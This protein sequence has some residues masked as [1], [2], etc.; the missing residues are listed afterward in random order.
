MW[1]GRKRIKS[2]KGVPNANVREKEY[3]KVVR[4]I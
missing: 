2:R 1:R 3:I 4:I